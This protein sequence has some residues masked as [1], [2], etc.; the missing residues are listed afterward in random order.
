MPP[1]A[2]QLRVPQRPDA[3]LQRGIG[4]SARFGGKALRKIPLIST[5]LGRITRG[6]ELDAEYWG[7]NIRRTVLFGAAVQAAM[8]RGLRTFLEVGPHPVLLGPVGECLGTESKPG[9][10]LPSMRRNHEELTVMLSSLGALYA[11]GPRGRV[12]KRLQQ[13]RTCGGPSGIPVS[14]STL[15]ARNTA[16]ATGRPIP[17]SNGSATAVAFHQRRCF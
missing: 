3:A 4:S 1:S 6:E 12:E 11:A 9:N 8:D 17:S 10:L 16:G 5:V 15:L 14:A 2:N 7:R 13:N